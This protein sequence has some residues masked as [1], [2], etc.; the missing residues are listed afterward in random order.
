MN[1]LLAFLGFLIYIG[2][3]MIKTKVK[4]ADKKF[5][6][7]KYL[8]D[9]SLTIVVSGLC[10]IV[11]MLIFPDVVKLLF[12]TY[13]GSDKLIS[14]IIGFSGYT[15]FDKIINSFLPKKFVEK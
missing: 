15:I 11:L 8:L 13:S 7:I 1:V 12:P 3:G 10:V 9:E 2:L 5:N 6:P 4:H 14:V